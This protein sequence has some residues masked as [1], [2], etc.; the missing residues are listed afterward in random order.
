MDRPSLRTVMLLLAV[1]VLL[2]CAGAATVGAG[3]HSDYRIYAKGLNVGELKTAVSALPGAGGTAFRFHSTMRIN[4][5]FL[6]YS[7]RQEISEDAVVGDEGMVSYHRTSV[8]NKVTTQ[9]DGKRE[10][11]RF[12][13]DVREG[14]KV[15]TV[16]FVRDQYDYSTME[17]P[18]LNLKKEGDRAT[19]RLLDVETLSVV[20]RAYRWAGN[21]DVAINGK[22]LRCRVV[23][24]EDPNKKG[25]RWVTRDERGV[26]IARQDGTGRNGTYSLRAREISPLPGS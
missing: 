4:A 15:R 21:E 18:E 3:R 17:C 11:N 14:E 23:E 24:F 20:N 2:P 7:F 5:S 6:F 25:K 19:M 13:F 12:T 10:G 9:V 26:I 22:V 1:I 8:E 16:S